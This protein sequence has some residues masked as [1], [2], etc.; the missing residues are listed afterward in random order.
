MK[1]SSQQLLFLVFVLGFAISAPLVVFYTAG[2]RYEFE[3]GRVVK[4]GV[5]SFST[6][7][8]GATLVI[9]GN[10][11]SSTTPVVIND[12]LPGVH[13][14]TMKKEGYTTW[15]KSLHVFS[16]S[17][18]FVENVVLFYE[19][20]LKF[21][22]GVATTSDIPAQPKM[23]AVFEGRTVKI[24]TL[25]D[26]AVL[27]FVDAADVSSIIAYLPAGDYTFAS[28]PSDILFLV[29]RQRERLV[30]V[31]PKSDQPILLHTAGTH[32]AWQERRSRLVFSDG[33]DVQTYDVPTH[34]RETLTRLSEPIVDLAWYPRGDV[35]LYATNVRINALELDRRGM[36]NRYD[37]GVLEQV[38]SFSLD[39]RGDV[40]TVIGKDGEQEGVFQRRLQK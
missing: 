13:T 31:D 27:A 16:Q 30:L 17:T 19:D 11:E 2:Y 20:P 8:R 12:V 3:G 40:L 15:T 10:E 39:E 7:P 24:S 32:S 4:T 38:E 23:E 1:T 6:F 21:I 9:N 5:L 28:S 35:V 25:P 26:R 22:E 34:N 29:D 36:Q 33:F 18:T 14:V 37:L